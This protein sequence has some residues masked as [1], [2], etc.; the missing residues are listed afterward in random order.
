MRQKLL[1]LGIVVLGMVAFVTSTA[2]AQTF[3]NG[4]Y[5]ATPSWD[6][7]LQCDTR[8]TCPRFI[9]LSNWG[10]VA[11]LDRET[12]LVWE[13]V[14]SPGVFNWPSAQFHCNNLTLGNRKGWRLPTVQELASLVDPSVSPTLPA[15]HPFLNVNPLFGYWSATTSA[16]NTGSAWVVYFASGFVEDSLKSGSGCAWCVRGGQGVDPQ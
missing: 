2:N 11:V 14:P 4:P 8:A 6:Q 15:G 1:A 9:V 7:K 3:A 16:L 10:N 13:L 5:Y 12:G